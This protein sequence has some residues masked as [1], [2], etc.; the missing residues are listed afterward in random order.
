MRKNFYEI[1][2]ELEKAKDT[3]T[4][5]NILRF[6]QTPALLDYFRYVYDPNVKF[7]VET[8]PTYKPDTS[9]PVGMSYTSIDQEIKR[10]YLFIQN[11]PKRPRELTDKRTTELLIQ[12][13]ENLE[14]KEA[15]LFVEMIQ[16]KSPVSRL[17]VE[18]AFPNFLG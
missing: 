1:F 2:D 17:L 4:R 11:H 16:K 12:V 10:A 6:N 3:A 18:M 7:C 5:I 15:A 14:G 9:T 8:I 13:L